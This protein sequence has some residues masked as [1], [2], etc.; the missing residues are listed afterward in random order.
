MLSAQ[1]SNVAV[2]TVDPC[3]L[4]VDATCT[5]ASR[6]NLR[7]IA[8]LTGGFAVTD[9]NAPEASVDRMLAEN[10]TVAGVPNRTSHV[11]KELLCCPAWDPVNWRYV[12]LVAKASSSGKR[13][14]RA[15]GVI[16]S[17]IA[18]ITCGT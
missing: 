9:T 6:Q 16:A 3:G 11:A 13:R 4:E 12:V 2:Y 1:R 10:G 7:T 14:R 5:K 8:E 17:A 18:A 15:Q